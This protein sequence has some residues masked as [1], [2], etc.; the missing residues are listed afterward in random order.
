MHTTCRSVQV[1]VAVACLW[2]LS[3]GCYLTSARSTDDRASAERAAAA[4]PLPTTCPYGHAT[5]KDTP[6]LYGMLIMTPELRRRID[7]GEV[8][9]G[10][11]CFIPAAS[12]DTMLV[13]TACKYQYNRL[14][15]EW[16]RTGDDPA[17]FERPLDRLVAEFPLPAPPG[18][19]LYGQT[20]RNGVVTD[21]SADCWTTRPAGEVEASVRAYL[22]RCN[23]AYRRHRSDDEGGESVSYTC[24]VGRRTFA[25]EVL[26]VKDVPGTHVSATLR[27]GVPL[28]PQ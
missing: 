5:L 9:A 27:E 12:P 14:T 16:H 17:G 15:A 20:L 19:A 11:C 6:V 26:H 13:C 18:Q 10:G 2:A 21:E 25:V 8:I 24:D 7:G 22:D 23:L 4:R 3:A 28:P 1:L